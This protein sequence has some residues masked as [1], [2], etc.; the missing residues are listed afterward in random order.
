[1]APHNPGELGKQNGRPV[2]YED[3][4][5]MGAVV[6]TPKLLTYSTE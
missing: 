5:E 1:M 4:M 3:T 2:S 6:V